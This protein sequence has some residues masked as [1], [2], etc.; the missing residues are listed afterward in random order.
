MP[1]TAIDKDHPVALLDR[2]DD[3]RASAPLAATEPT[4]T[5][6]RDGGVPDNEDPIDV[7]YRLHGRPLY[8][9]LLRITFGDRLE[10][11]DLLQETLFRAWRFLQA[12]TTD[13]EC[14]RPWLYTVA[15]RVAID[16]ARA[17]HA[18]PTEVTIAD[19]DTLPSGHDDIERIL[20]VLTIRRALMSLS[21]DHRQVLV[22]IYYH[23]R[24]V[25][26]A[27]EVLGIPEGTAKS[28]AFYALRALAAAAGETGSRRLGAVLNEGSRTPKGTTAPPER[29]PA[30][31]GCGAAAAAVPI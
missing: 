5:Q 21:K 9:Y 22:E 10:A 30:T 25:L 27:A 29:E 23:G 17:R 31:S 1:D 6:L 12:N 7:I 18:R 14:L 13:L 19:A 24:S 2:H 15:K 26:E 20:V 4:V 28:R 11:E 8:R 3:M 16:A